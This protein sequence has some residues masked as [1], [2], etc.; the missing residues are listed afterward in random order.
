MAIPAIVV[1][2][3]DQQYLALMDELLTEEGYRVIP[4]TE[5]EH[6]YDLVRREQPALLILDIRLEH[7]EA[8]WRVLEF[9]RLAPETRRLPVIVC[10]ADRQFLRAKEEQLRAKGCDILEKP[11]DI[12]ELLLKIAAARAAVRARRSEG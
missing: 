11:F 9:L 4:C 10:S 12:D 2:N 8:G 6:V 5:T 7:P 3:D 1:V